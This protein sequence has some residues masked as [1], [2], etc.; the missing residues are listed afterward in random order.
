MR[1]YIV[2]AVLIIS[3]FIDFVFFDYNISD[4]GHK[5]EDTTEIVEKLTNSM[6]ME[7]PIYFQK[8][9]FHIKNCRDYYKYKPEAANAFERENLRDLENKCDL[10]KIMLYAKVSK[11]SFLD[12]ILLTNYSEWSSS[13]LFEHTCSKI[14]M[15]KYEDVLNNNKSVSDLLKNGLIEVQI[16]NQNELVV[17]NKVID[18]KFY[19]K[20]IFRANFDDDDENR[21]VL[22]KIS[23]SDPT[24]NY[25]E[26]NKYIVFSR[27]NTDNLLKERKIKFRKKIKNRF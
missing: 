18:K 12:T 11:N 20:E 4:I 25:I 2:V 9:G 23:Q 14:D 27:A 7:F 15:K 16:I 21:D 26:C 13:L 8:L 1:K 24:E 6:T 22:V 3:L 5:R 17:Y 19:I 10:I